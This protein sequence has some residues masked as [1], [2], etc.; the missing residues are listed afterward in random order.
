MLASYFRSSIIDDRMMKCRVLWLILYWF[1][2]IRMLI[3]DFHYIYIFAFRC[4]L[5][6]STSVVARSYGPV[7]TSLYQQARAHAA[8]RSTSISSGA[9]TP[10]NMSFLLFDAKNA[11]KMAATP[12]SAL[13]RWWYISYIQIRTSSARCNTTRTASAMIS[14]EC[15]FWWFSWWLPLEAWL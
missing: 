15:Q 7:I 8:G 9:F 10:S 12:L 4:W 6:K 3:A 5:Y 11:I 13:K 14:R 2:I 1:L